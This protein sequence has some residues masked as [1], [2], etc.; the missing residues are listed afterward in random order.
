MIG[1]SEGAWT[2][3]A[4]IMAGVTSRADCF[5]GWSF[6]Y[7]DTWKATLDPT[8]SNFEWNN[9]IS[10]GDGYWSGAYSWYP[11]SP[12]AISDM[13]MASFD[14]NKYAGSMYAGLIK[15]AQFYGMEQLP[16]STD[17]EVIHGVPFYKIEFVNTASNRV[18]RLFYD[19]DPS[20]DHSWLA[21]DSMVYWSTGM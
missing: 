1:Y 11:A 4:M 10:Q 5:A 14:A 9:Y 16:I 18:M 15:I 20:H 19:A 3:S 7:F 21:T 12:N 2:S 8:V 17:T 6:Q 13:N